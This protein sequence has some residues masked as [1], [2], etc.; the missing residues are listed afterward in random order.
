MSDNLSFIRQFRTN[1]ID[2]SWTCHEVLVGFIIDDRNWFVGIIF[3]ITLQESPL[4]WASFSLQEKWALK[5]PVVSG[6]EGTAWCL[7]WERGQSLADLFLRCNL[8]FYARVYM[9]KSLCWKVMHGTQTCY[10]THEQHPHSSEY[11]R[12]VPPSTTT[13]FVFG[14]KHTKYIKLKTVL[15]IQDTDRDGLV[16]KKQT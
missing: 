5:M 9:S 3:T 10:T 15:R 2:F 14:I 13:V 11:S 1:T 12:N 7:H 8:S 6:K 16:W 4:L